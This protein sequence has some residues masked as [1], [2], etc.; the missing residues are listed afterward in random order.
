MP[1]K[2][3]MTATRPCPK[4]GKRYHYRKA[5]CPHCGATN[6]RRLT[7]EIGPARHFELMES[8][9]SWV[10]EMGGSKAVD[11]LFSKL[12]ALKEQFGTLENARIY[13]D[14]VKRKK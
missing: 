4:C 7:V 2:K 12:D 11:A 14:R 5:E 6:P 13:I 10:T 9:E 8:A 3:S 1:K